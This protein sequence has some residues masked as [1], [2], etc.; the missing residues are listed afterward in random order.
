M[1]VERAETKPTKV[2][3]VRVGEIEIGKEGKPPVL[4]I[5]PCA[6]ENRRQ[7]K[8]AFATAKYITKTTGLEVILRGGTKKPR[9]NWESPQGLGLEALEMMIEMKTRYQIPIA[10]EILSELD[11]ESYLPHVDLGWIGACN[12]CNYELLKAIAQASVKYGVP[13]MLKRAMNAKLPKWI[14]A[15]EYL[16]HVWGQDPQVLLCERGVDSNP[17]DQQSSRVLDLEGMVEASKITGAPV[18]A[19][20]SHGTYM[21]NRVIWAMLAAREFAHAIMFE[22]HPWPDKAISDQRHQLN[23][24]KAVTAARQIADPTVS[25][26]DV[27]QKTKGWVNWPSNIRP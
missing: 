10:T 6:V 14:G 19:D 13:L 3:I 5:G 4:I 24:K 26:G 23:L 22:Y 2:N 7:L 11:V 16:T 27:Y 20:V 15:A 8:A 25:L 12:G 18:C 9:T 21:E 1:A 17:L